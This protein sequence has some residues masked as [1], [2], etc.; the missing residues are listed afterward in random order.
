M[1]YL[2]KLLAFVLLPQKKWEEEWV[3]ALAEFFGEVEHFGDF[4]PFDKTNYYE[5]EMGQGLY[6]TV[7]SFKGLIA[8][9]NIGEF[10]R[11]SIELEGRFK[12]GGGRVLNIDIGYMDTDKVVLP[13]TKRGPFKL[14]MGDNI[15]LD[16]LLTYAKGN[17]YPTAWAFADFKENIYKRDLLIIREKYK[18][19][20]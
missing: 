15:W 8:P 3:S 19:D 14:Y 13:S 5:R 9:E 11:K 17:F 7:I 16:M 12:R 6:R 2:A 1:P 20:I 4:F 10:K 18:F